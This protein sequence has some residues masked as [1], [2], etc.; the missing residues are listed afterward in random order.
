M[1][2]DLSS[3]WQE[4]CSNISV[5]Y[6]K[7]LLEMNFNRPKREKKTSPKT[8]NVTIIV[9]IVHQI[10]YEIAFKYKYICKYCSGSAR[11]ER[12]HTD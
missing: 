8:K 1:G 3:L 7:I 4:I 6:Q 12:I 11:N 10:L 5:K 2:Q 9:S